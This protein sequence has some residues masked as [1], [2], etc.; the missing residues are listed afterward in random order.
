MSS[1]SLIPLSANQIENRLRQHNTGAFGARVHYVR[2]TRSTNDIAKK[3]VADG[4]PQGTLVIAD[5]QTA[6]RG[7]MGR[8]WLAPPYSALLMS[9]IFRPSQRMLPD[10]ANR[11][12]MACGMAACEAIE[13]L[14]GL[15]VDVKWPND[16]QMRG[17]KVAGILSESAVLG[18]RLEYVIV[19][20][21]LNVN[22]R[23]EFFDEVS[24]PATSL[25]CELGQPVNRLALLAEILERL[26]FWHDLIESSQ[27][28]R[29]WQARMLTIGQRIEAGDIVGIAERIDRCGQL[30]I[31][32]D[33]G[34]LVQL[35]AQEG[36]L[37]QSGAAHSKA[38]SE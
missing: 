32:R 6:G 30:W 8:R 35:D 3:L 21:G 2:R 29:A 24:Y 16:L 33:S 7:R 19:G 12:V 18:S 26:N 27:L 15:S 9:L 1:D 20:M 31:R 4:A 36:S 10:E 34:Q 5:E 13:T 22:M 25:Q 28:E 37:R 23:Q 17:S 38:T 11:L 14:T